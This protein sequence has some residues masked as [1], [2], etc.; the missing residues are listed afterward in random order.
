LLPA[1]LVA[2]LVQQDLAQIGQEAAGVPR[3]ELADVVQRAY[4]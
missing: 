4:Q 1:Q 3:V 2:H